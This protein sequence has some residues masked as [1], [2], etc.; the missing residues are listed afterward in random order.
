MSKRT[1]KPPRELNYTKEEK[2]IIAATIAAIIA[3]II[4]LVIMIALV[5]G[6]AQWTK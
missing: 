2:Q 4:V 3:S 6:V 1:R 5:V